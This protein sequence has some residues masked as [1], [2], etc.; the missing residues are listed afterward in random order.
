MI[1]MRPDFFSFSAGQRFKSH[2]QIPPP[3]VLK[4]IWFLRGL[5][6]VQAYIALRTCEV[7]LDNSS[8]RSG[9]KFI[10]SD[11]KYSLTAITNSSAAVSFYTCRTV[12]SSHK[13]TFIWIHYFC[14]FLKKW[15]HTLKTVVSFVVISLW[16]KS[17]K[18]CKG[19]K[20]FFT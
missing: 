11:V 4:N 20:F 3:S 13:A 7:T 17:K 12:S 6:K 9:S 16:L 18:I 1:R 8:K 2:Q 14:Y 19:S 10:D 5:V 15:N